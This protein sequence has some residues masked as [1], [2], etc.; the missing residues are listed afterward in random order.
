LVSLDINRFQ[1]ALKDLNIA[2]FEKESELW[3]KSNPVRI[4]ARECWLDKEITKIPR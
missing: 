4:K 1:G 3:Q 2:Q